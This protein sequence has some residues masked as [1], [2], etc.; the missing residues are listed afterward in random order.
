MDKKE[1]LE[2]SLE[3]RIAE[4]AGYQLNIDSYEL[5]I[6]KIDAEYNDSQDAL[7][8]KEHL[9]GLLEGHYREQLKAIIMKEVVEEQLKELN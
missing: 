1:T 4:I 7:K 5:A 6:K 2:K 3:G 9:Q 8:F